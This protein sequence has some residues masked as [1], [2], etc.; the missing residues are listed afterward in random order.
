MSP[1][2][3]PTRIRFAVAPPPVEGQHAEHYFHALLTRCGY[4]MDIEADH[5]YRAR[6]VSHQI[7]LI[8]QRAASGPS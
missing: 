1:L 4:L 5:R 3:A 2:S 7:E 6:I 8:V